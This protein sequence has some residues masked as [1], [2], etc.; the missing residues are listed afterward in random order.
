MSHP[1]DILPLPN[2]AKFVFT[3]CPGT[4]SADLAESLSTLKGAGVEAIVTMLPSEEIKA[5]NVPTLGSDINAF[6]MQWFQL[7]VADDQSPEQDF[8]DAFEQAKPKL[9]ELVEQQATIAIHCRGGSGRTGLMAAILLL[10]MG[11]SWDDVKS[12]VQSIRPKALTLTP[13]L[14]F[15]QANYLV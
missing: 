4:K 1:Y 5:L 6:N 7:P 9:I 15:L 10:E 8:F 3:P 11:H 2:G 14:S 12:W 13:H